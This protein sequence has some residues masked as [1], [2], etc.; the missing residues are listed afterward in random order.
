MVLFRPAKEGTVD[1]DK[2]L[3]GL[4]S[5]ICLLAVNIALVYATVVYGL[6]IEPKSWLVFWFCYVAIG[7]LTRALRAI[8]KAGDA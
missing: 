5:I 8:A 4:A 6:G 2:A 7:F 3:V 1:N